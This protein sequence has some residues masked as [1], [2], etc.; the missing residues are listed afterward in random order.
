MLNSYRW[1]VDTQNKRGFAGAGQIR[2]V[3]FGKLLVENKTSAANFQS[4]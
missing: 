1:L 2:P 4:F 3:K